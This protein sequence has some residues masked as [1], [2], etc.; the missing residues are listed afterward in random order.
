MQAPN[1]IQPTAPRQTRF[2][3][4][5][6]DV[7]ITSGP[8]WGWIYSPSGH[9]AMSGDMFDPHTWRGDTTGEHRQVTPA[10]LVNTRDRMPAVPV[11]SHPPPVSPAPKLRNHGLYEK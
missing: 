8:N 7:F 1:L 10:M 9:S 3:L 2:S 11:E 5:F 4:L 6:S